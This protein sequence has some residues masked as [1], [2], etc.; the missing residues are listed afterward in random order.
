MMEDWIPTELKLII[1]SLLGTPLHTHM[2]Y[3][4]LFYCDVYCFFIVSDP[5]TLDSESLFSV[6]AVCKSWNEVSDDSDLWAIH[7]RKH[8]PYI[9]PYLL[10]CQPHLG[11]KQL[12]NQEHVFLKRARIKACARDARTKHINP[13][14]NNNS[15]ISNLINIKMS[16]LGDAQTGKT[17]FLLRYVNQQ[18]NPDY[19]LTSDE[20]MYISSPLSYYLLARSLYSSSSPILL[21]FFDLNYKCLASLGGRR[22]NLLLCDVP[23]SKSTV[24]DDPTIRFPVSWYFSFCLLFLR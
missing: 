20:D 4:D 8:F 15:R 13:D 10:P 16:L 2:L 18:Y 5:K 17:T 1:F 11:F 21:P 12:F 22:I 9:S 6:S 19:Y 24:S 14:S 7:F 3:T 23:G